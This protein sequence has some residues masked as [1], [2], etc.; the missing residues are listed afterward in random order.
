MG[1]FEYF[2]LGNGAPLPTATHEM[3]H[4]YSALTVVHLPV[5]VVDPW[6]DH[7][8]HPRIQGGALVQEEDVRDRGCNRG[9]EGGRVGG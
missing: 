7:C 1:R 3:F 5:L 9:V 8:L 4:R 2:D 6:S